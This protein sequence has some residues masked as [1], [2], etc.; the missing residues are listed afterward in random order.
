MNTPSRLDRFLSRLSYPATVA[1]RRPSSP[2]VSLPHSPLLPALSFPQILSKKRRLRTKSL[3]ATLESG[4]LIN[5]READREED[6]GAERQANHLPLQ[7][8]SVDFVEPDLLG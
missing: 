6:I 7:R 1:S 8:P 5:V 3:L 4:P 2:C